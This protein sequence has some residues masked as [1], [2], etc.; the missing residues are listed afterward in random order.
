MT[1]TPIF[2]ASPPETAARSLY[3]EE[4]A[5]DPAKSPFSPPSLTPFIRQFPNPVP[6]TALL[7]AETGVFRI[8]STMNHIE[9]RAREGM[10]EID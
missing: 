6:P 4:I 2:R 5:A 9:Q 3:S 8:G 10:S 1:F 7:T